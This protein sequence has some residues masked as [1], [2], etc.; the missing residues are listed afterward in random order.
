MGK[1][2]GDRPEMYCLLNNPMYNRNQAM[3]CGITNFQ[4]LT[5][6]S[7]SAMPN[8]RALTLSC[9][10]NVNHPQAGLPAE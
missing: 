3:S 1:R 8:C 9:P 2:P 7:P 4:P 10:M 5:A 6:K